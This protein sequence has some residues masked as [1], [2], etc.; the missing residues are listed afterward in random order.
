MIT[1]RYVPHFMIRNTNTIPQYKH[2]KAVTPLE[3]DQQK[4][5]LK[6]ASEKKSSLRNED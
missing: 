3:P 5:F 1:L 2:H 4:K 6:K